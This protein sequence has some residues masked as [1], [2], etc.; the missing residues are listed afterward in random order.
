[1]FST[2]QSISTIYNSSQQDLSNDNFLLFFLL[3]TY[4]QSNELATYEQSNELATG[5]NHTQ[6]RQYQGNLSNNNRSYLRFTTIARP[7]KQR[8][9]K[10][11]GH[12]FQIMRWME[13]NVGICSRR[14]ANHEHENAK[15][16][17]SRMK[18]IE[19]ATGS[20]KNLVTVHVW[21]YL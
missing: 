11:Y 18:V 19:R 21:V 15:V 6:H 5:S 9:N 12:F 14:L 4:E 16:R 10:T 7:S 13:T 20:T 17:H 3:A 2:F 8:P 1:V